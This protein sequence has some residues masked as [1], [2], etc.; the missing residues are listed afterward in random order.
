MAECAH[1]IAFLHTAAAHVPTFESLV[2]ERAPALAQ[3]HD[4]DASLLAQA[5]EPTPVSTG[6]QKRIHAAMREAASTDAIVLAQASMAGATAYCE[7]LQ[8]P[9]LSS[10][11]LGVERALEHFVDLSRSGSKT[12]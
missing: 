10:P 1:Q 4:V 3:R 7:H 2:A 8:A 5:R 11:V 9:V 12:R 6:L